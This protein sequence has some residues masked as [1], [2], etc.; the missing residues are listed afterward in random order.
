MSDDSSTN[1]PLG[2]SPALDVLRQVPMLQYLNDEECRQVAQAARVMEFAS[3]TDIVKQGA[4]CQNLWIVLAGECDVVKQLG[5]GAARR[6]VVLAT[7][8]P[9]DNFGEMSFFQ[10]APHSAAVRARGA[11]R[12]LRIARAEYNE[13]IDHGVGA[14]YK[15]AYNT[16]QS[17]AER[18]RRM[19][20]WVAT[21]VSENEKKKQPS[22]EWLDFRDQLLKQWNL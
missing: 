8:R 4:M 1:T 21:L 2:E 11:V 7:L 15:L 17:L 19:D 14:A 22:R 5:E 6:E 20:D 10:P 16:V 9:F 13:M 12:L 18:L 3:G